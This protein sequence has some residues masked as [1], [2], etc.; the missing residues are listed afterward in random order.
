MHNFLFKYLGIMI[1]F[2]PNSNLYQDSI[3]WLRHLVLLSHSIQ[4][5][6]MQTADEDKGCAV[7]NCMHHGLMQ[8]M[9]MDPTS[10]LA[11]R[12]LQSKTLI[13]NLNFVASSINNN[14]HMEQISKQM[15]LF[16]P[17]ISVG[18]DS[19]EHFHVA[20]NDLIS[21]SYLRMLSR[22][23]IHVI[24]Q[25]TEVWPLSRIDNEMSSLQG[26]KFSWNTMNSSSW[27]NFS[28]MTQKSKA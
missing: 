24:L 3:S 27:K 10:E 20:I 14:L 1:T 12:V 7:S 18:N 15:F 17:H 22:V 9:C 4:I 25:L 28:C 23:C 8:D 5:P 6:P 2:I 26:T 11:W 19:N 13:I 16:F 21:L